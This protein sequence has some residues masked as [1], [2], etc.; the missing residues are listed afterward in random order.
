MH[1][2]YDPLIDCVDTLRAEVRRAVSSIAYCA[3]CR[4][5]RHSFSSQRTSR[6]RGQKSSYVMGYWAIYNIN[7]PLKQTVCVNKSCS[8]SHRGVADRGIFH[9]RSFV[10]SPTPDG[11]VYCDYSRLIIIVTEMNHVN[12]VNRLLLQLDVPQFG[13]HVHGPNGAV[14]VDV[15]N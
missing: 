3:V 15:H 1:E 11:H 10:R 8:L 7:D 6:T 9:D 14:I 4:N 13:M 5:A 12:T 2:L